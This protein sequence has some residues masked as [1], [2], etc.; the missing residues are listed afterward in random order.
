MVLG[1]AREHYRCYTCYKPQTKAEV[2]ADTVEFSPHQYNLLH[3]TPTKDAAVTATDLV[4][5]ITNPAPQLHW[6]KL[7]NEILQAVRQLGD[8]FQQIV[9][10]QKRQTTQQTIPIMKNAK[11]TDILKMKQTNNPQ[12]NTKSMAVPEPRVQAAYKPKLTPELTEYPASNNRPHVIP[13][14]NEESTGA[15]ELRMQL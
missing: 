7:E 2:Q 3:I 12:A 8:I 13:D 6:D 9:S 15:P 4:K 5:A 14:D 10:K 1:T 11:P